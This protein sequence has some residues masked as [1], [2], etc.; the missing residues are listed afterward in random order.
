MG[1]NAF[2][3]ILRSSAFPRL[4]PKVYHALQMRI[5][6]LLEELYIHVGIPRVAPEKVDYG[7]LD[8]IVCL[9]RQHT[10]P[11]QSSVA[12]NTSDSEQR[13][14]VHV[15]HEIVAATIK[16]RHLNPMDGNRISNYAIPILEGE[17]A[18]YGLAEATAEDKARKD[19]GEEGIFYQVRQ[20]IAWIL[21]LSQEKFR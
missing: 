21:N 11:T 6:P 1:G 16:A 17:W 13:L 15:S 4:P 2:G 8:L 7:D 19:A 20:S 3:S 14:S 9:P 18:V 5:R 12:F 10:I